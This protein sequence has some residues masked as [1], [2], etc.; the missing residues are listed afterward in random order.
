MVV[1]KRSVKAVEKSASLPVSAMEVPDDKIEGV[2]EACKRLGMGLD[3]YLKAIKEALS[4]EIVVTNK[5]GDVSSTPDHE[6]RLKAALLGLQVEGYWK[7]ADKGVDNSRHTNVIYSWNP[8]QVITADSTK[9]TSSRGA[10]ARDD[11]A[12]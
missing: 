11:G 7:A 3:D 4:A 6:K 12:E 9:G 8:V 5:F 10:S 2:R 1:E